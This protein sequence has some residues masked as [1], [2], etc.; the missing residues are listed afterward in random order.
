MEQVQMEYWEVNIWKVKEFNF[1]NEKSRNLQTGGV[2]AWWEALAIWRKKP[3]N[4]VYEAYIVY[5]VF[6][7][8][9][10]ICY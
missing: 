2:R 4:I 5:V 9:K 8:D 7:S 1:L 6:H 3:S 10:V